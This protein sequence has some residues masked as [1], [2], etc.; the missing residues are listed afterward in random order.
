MPRL[1]TT[2]VMGSQVTSSSSPEPW[3][4]PRR[5][6]IALFSFDAAWHRLIGGRLVRATA[7]L[8][9]PIHRVDGKAPQRCH[10]A[11][12]HHHGRRRHLRARRLI[13]E[14]HELVGKPGHRTTDANP[15]DIRASAD[16]THPSAFADVASHYRPPASELDDTFGTAV[17]LLEISLFVVTAAIASLVHRLLE[18]PARTQAI[19]K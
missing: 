1:P 13:H 16:T 3:P 5:L 10:R 18:Q 14:G 19:I 12:I 15:A 6:A 2:R 11:P 7:P 8:R 9:F 4:P 17:L